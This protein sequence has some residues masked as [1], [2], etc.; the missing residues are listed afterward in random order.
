MPS[1]PLLRLQTGSLYASNDESYFTGTGGPFGFSPF[2]SQF[3][4]VVSS[5]GIDAEPF[6]DTVY[7]VRAGDEVIFVIAVQN[8]TAGASAYDVRLHV[9]LPAGFLIPPDEL[10]LSATDGAGTDLAVSGSLFGPD[11]LALTA[12]IGGYDRD[13][14][15]N[16]AL[17]TYALI[18]GPSLPGPYATIP[19]QAS[20]VR[21]ASAA[22]G[23]NLAAAAPP[24]ASTVVISAAPVPIVTAPG[25]SVVAKGQLIAFDVTIPIPVGTLR[26]VRLESVMPGGAAQLALIS[27]EVT[28]IGAGLRVSGTTVNADGS[29]AFGSV[30]NGGTAP[31]ADATITVR[32]FTLAQG[33][34]SGEALIRTIL[35]TATA[36]GGPRW[37][38]SVSSSVDVIVPP[39][40]PDIAGLWTSQRAA[41]GM[42]FHALGALSIGSAETSR[43]G[44]LAIT[45]QDGSLGRLS[46]SAAAGSFDAAGT[47]FVATGTFADLQAA[48]RQ[49]VFTS[50]ALGTERLTVTII[51]Q[52]GGIAQTEGAV[53]AIAPPAVPG[54]FAIDPGVTVWV[55]DLRGIYVFSG[56]GATLQSDLPPQSAAIPTLV[57]FGTGNQ[58]ILP[59]L[60]RAVSYTPSSDGSGLLT[61]NGS[62]VRLIGDYSRTIFS[63]TSL[64]GG[65]TALTATAVPQPRPL[66]DDDYYLAHNP[67]VAASGNNPSAHFHDYGWKEGRDPSAAFSTQAYLAKYPDVRQAGMDPLMHYLVYGQYEGRTITPAQVTADPLIDST[68]YRATYADVRMSGAD[69]AQHYLRYGS[70]EGRNP[71]A[72]FDTNYYLTQNADVRASGVNPLLHYE[73]FGFKEGR[74]PSLLFSVDKYLAAYPTVKAAGT[75]ALADYLTNG[76]DAGRMS[77]LVGGTAP[78]DPLVD[79]AFYARQLGATLVPSGLAGQQQAAWSYST[80]GWQKG[81]DPDAWFDTKY[82]L[83]HNPDVAAAHIDPLKHYEDYGWKEHRDPSAVFSNDRYLAVYSDVRDAR[84]NPLIHYVVTGQG[85]GRAS[86]SV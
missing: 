25:G 23:T 67:D 29:I 17:V 27:A 21:Y 74:D 35:S 5:A 15:R 56:P 71:D 55:T 62:T 2:T 84:V 52:V 34:A 75:D 37:S 26:D 73:A 53:I 83:N 33:S 61:A 79:P 11:G 46:G 44:T 20:I 7:G 47:S 76:R 51:D 10:N 77:F 85:E 41:P 13:S 70:V 69:P 54:E 31:G 16:V 1:N 82:Y 68:Y 63:T 39:A 80:S 49:V 42:A 81:L 8:V 43:T 28:A 40:P 19:S 4:G 32:F 6:D 78:A 12:P 59:G 9:D 48:A 14:G 36:G 65:L 58:L 38:A 30:V 45:L 50:A 64:S 86:F 24:T 18:A 22:G 57:G 66:F 60:G 3:G 72:F